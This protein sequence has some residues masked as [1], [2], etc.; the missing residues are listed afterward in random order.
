MRILAEGLQFPWASITV[1]YP[2]WACFL[3]FKMEMRK[4]Y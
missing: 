2:N 3:I 1:R 4:V